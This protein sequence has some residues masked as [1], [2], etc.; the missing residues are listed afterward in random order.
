MLDRLD[1]V[2]SKNPSFDP[3]ADVI[4]NILVIFVFHANLRVT[5]TFQR[6]NWIMA[7]SKTHSKRP[8]KVLKQF[9]EIYRNVFTA[10]IESIDIKERME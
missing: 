6:N 4:L 2:F 8:S 5:L 3:V 1:G 10:L 9:D 7:T